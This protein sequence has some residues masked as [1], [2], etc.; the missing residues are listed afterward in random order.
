MAGCYLIAPPLALSVAGALVMA[1][2]LAR[3]RGI[4]R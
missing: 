2:G 1:L 4:K 3:L